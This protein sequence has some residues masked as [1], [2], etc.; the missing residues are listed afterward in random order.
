MAGARPGAPMRP[1][2]RPS[3]HWTEPPLATE[4]CWLEIRARANLR[5]VEEER[6]V[7]DAIRAK[8]PD[9]IRQMRTF[10]VLPPDEPAVRAVHTVSLRDFVASSHSHRTR[11]REKSVLC[12]VDL[13]EGT[14]WATSVLPSHVAEKILDWET[15]SAQQ[16]VLKGLDECLPR[17]PAFVLREDGELWQNLKDK[18][19]A[20]WASC[21]SKYMAALGHIAE[22]H[23]KAKALLDE[24]D[25]L[26]AAW[27]TTHSRHSRVWAR[28]SGQTATLVELWVEP[29]KFGERVNP[30]RVRSL[31]NEHEAF[32]CLDPAHAATCSSASAADRTFAQR[33][34]ALRQ[35]L[36]CADDLLQVR[37]KMSE[38]LDK[39]RVRWLASPSD[40]DGLL[41]RVQLREL[42]S[43]LLGRTPGQQS[44]PHSEPHSQPQMPDGARPAQGPEVQPHRGSRRQGRGGAGGY[45]V[46]AALWRIRRVGLLRCLREG[47][48]GAEQ[49]ATAARH[50][51]GATGV[52]ASQMYAGALAVVGAGAYSQAVVEGDTYS[53]VWTQMRLP[54]LHALAGE[55][56]A[57]AG[58][59]EW[60]ESGER[61]PWLRG[62]CM[63]EP[64]SELLACVPLQLFELLVKCLRLRACPRAE[65]GDCSQ[66]G[67]RVWGGASRT[68]A[69]AT[70]D[71][72]AAEDVVEKALVGA[73]GSESAAEVGADG[74]FDDDRAL[75]R[76]HLE[77]QECMDAWD[78]AG[79]FLRVLGAHV[80][81]QRAATAW[82][83]AQ[84]ALRQQLLA[85]LDDTLAT[86]MRLQGKPLLSLPAPPPLL[87]GA[88]TR[89]DEDDDDDDGSHIWRHALAARSEWIQRGARHFHSHGAAWRRRALSCWTPAAERRAAALQVDFAGTLLAE[90]EAM[91]ARAK[92]ALDAQVRSCIVQCV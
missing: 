40:L 53:Q 84:Q 28:E 1:T 79:V 2:S 75:V 57:G 41:L 92:G 49:A 51:Q 24:L 55:G 63:S 91:L 43:S 18:S 54:A 32:Q 64:L 71:D 69:A 3:W 27:P 76:A 77:Y 14:W 34:H 42:T 72:D 80:G 88:H 44:P 60:G 73:R 9:L 74:V 17:L 33:Y 89:G 12:N 16:E 6:K 62:E 56:T 22:C 85:L 7:V 10:C 30:N 59:E 15:G 87:A 83:R 70:T 58:G 13:K 4:Q 48:G 67:P 37:A 38:L 66:A 50:G 19:P 45:G 90:A 86:C 47:E 61:G 82:T 36:S 39:A 5:T 26:E 68:A 20:E 46:L 78:E 8:A 35:W 25:E 81:G 65:P 23:K 21:A 11:R 31:C 29:P 52:G